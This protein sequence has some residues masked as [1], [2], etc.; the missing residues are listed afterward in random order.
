MDDEY[1][2][3]VV[4]AGAAGLPAAI[5]A[6]ENG[7]RVLL[8]EAADVI[9][10]TFH[11]S[12]GQMSAAGTR[13]QQAKGIEDSAD[14]HFDDVMRISRGTVDADLVRLA[15]D[16]AAD[17]LHWLLDLGLVVDPAHPVIHYG[18]EPY[19]IPRTYWAAEGGLSV[20]KVLGP[21]A[22]RTARER[23]LTIRT[24]TRMSQL[25]RDDAG[26]V[27]G[28]EVESDGDTRS[29]KAQAVL[30]TC[31]GY[32]ANPDLFAS[33][34]GRPLYGGG[35]PQ[36]QGSGMRAALDVG[37][38]VSGGE[39]FLPTFA[40]VAEPTAPGGY[41]FLTET[42]PQFRQPWEVYLDLDG[43]RFM[44]ED[45]PSV[46]ARERALL[47][48]RDMS[49]WAVFDARIRR[50]APSFF[51]ID[52]EAVERNFADNPAFVTAESLDDLAQATGMD[53]ALVARSIA[54]FNAAIA[55]GDPDSQG[56]EHRPLPVAE[57]PFHAVRHVG[58]SIVGFAGVDIDT[59]L[60]VLDTQ[61]RP[62]PGLYAAGE[63]IGFSK[64]SGNAFVGGMSVT[65]A[66][67]FGRLFGETIAERIDLAGAG[68]GPSP[69]DADKV[70][71]APG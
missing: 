59:R 70:Q 36:S 71:G 64:T 24:A 66:M 50:E 29:V 46:D 25:L 32:S 48:T 67:T 1:D 9:G 18:H 63:V 26:R 23:D 42:Y 62:I 56:R 51:L 33:M 39:K 7:A 47:A 3:V 6:A 12:S 28:V 19:A 55:G 68:D 65:P 60:R 20:L 21:L 2:L 10:G 37:A 40:A 57:P 8:V 52:P 38:R 5:K 53:P 11:L 27:T 15:V 41:T 54:D 13:I 35:Y 30:L 22:E 14:R 4:G 58:W 17:T 61:G 31:G 43:R 45:E 49:F 34:S 16:N 69:R 44:R